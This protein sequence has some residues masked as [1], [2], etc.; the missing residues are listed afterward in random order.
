MS[1]TWCT[2]NLKRTY[3]SPSRGVLFP[4]GV[5]LFPF[6]IFIQ[7]V[8]FEIDFP[9]PTLSRDPMSHPALKLEASNKQIQMGLKS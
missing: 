7:F 2:N 3:F 9:C 4:G 1:K 8:F 5:L 6:F